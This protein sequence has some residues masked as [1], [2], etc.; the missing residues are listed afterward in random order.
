MFLTSGTHNPNSIINLNQIE[1]VE[2]ANSS[3]YSAQRAFAIQNE[4]IYQIRFH[5]TSG[6]TL[7][8]DYPTEEMRDKSFDNIGIEY[9]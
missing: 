1:Y 3:Q 8:W 5:F 6:K 4:K 9:A 2:K 7:L